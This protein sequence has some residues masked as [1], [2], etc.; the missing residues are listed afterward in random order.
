MSDWTASDV[1]AS[2]LPE[3]KP[4][5]AI[6]QVARAVFSVTVAPTPEDVA[7][8]RVKHEE[9]QRVLGVIPNY[10]VA[11]GNAAPLSS[12]Q[13][14]YLTSKTLVDPATFAAVGI[15]AGIQQSMN[16][17]HQFGQVAAPEGKPMDA[18][19]QRMHS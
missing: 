19:E 11:Y 6:M 8:E 18:D 15:T 17:Y 13:K 14:F 1:P 4:L 2:P 3:S 10:Y 12:T 5:L 9:Q 16:T 7:E